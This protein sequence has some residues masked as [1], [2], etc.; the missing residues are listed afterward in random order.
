MFESC[1]AHQAFQ[2]LTLLIRQSDHASR[3]WG[4]VR[5]VDSW[6][7]RGWREAARRR[8]SQFSPAR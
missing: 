2:E 7:R 1:R 4:V 3:H 8:N 5:C 6:R